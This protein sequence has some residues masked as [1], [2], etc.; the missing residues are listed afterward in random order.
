M[1]EIK[2]GVIKPVEC[3]K[4]G[5]ELIKNDY[6]IL[7]A[8]S[9]VGGLIGGMSF[10][11]LL[12]AMMCGIYYCFLQTIDG[13]PASFDGLWKGFSYFLP[14]LLVTIL[15]VV[16][17]LVIFGVI[18]APLIMAAVMGSKLSPQELMGLMFG[19]LALDV[20]LAVI[21]ICFHTLLMFSFPLIIDRN[22]GAWAA[23]TTSAKAV[24]RNLG[25]VVGLIGIGIV[26]SL[27]GIITC[28]FGMYF[29]MPIMLAG[30]A[31]AYRKIFPAQSNRNIN[32]PTPDFYK[33]F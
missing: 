25:G 2:T 11:V 13:K 12:G 6:W 24:W 17:M 20:V 23:V 10:Y 15:I 30:Y 27:F 22:L 16:P 29:I 18:Y 33:G 9:L 31:V 4:E 14:G 26:L 8:V 19:A 21:M 5:W 28:G 7:F 32:P 3:F 1:T